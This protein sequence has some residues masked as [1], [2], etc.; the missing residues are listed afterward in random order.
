MFVGL[1]GA[2][3]GTTPNLTNTNDAAAVSTATQSPAPPTVQADPGGGSTQSV[4][5]M[6]QDSGND[7]VLTIPSEGSGNYNEFCGDK[8]TKA[9][10]LDTEMYSYCLQ[11]E[12]QGFRDLANAVS[13]HD[14]M[15]NAQLL[16]N[17]IVDEWTKNGSRDDNEIVF[18]FK[19]QIADFQDLKWLERDRLRCAHLS[20]PKT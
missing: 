11:Q 17:S 13:D 18:I 20:A 3:S 7:A 5:A 8:W 12:D 4:A 6:L 2:N 19:Q 16:L 10:V 1:I 15:P 14:G 9:G